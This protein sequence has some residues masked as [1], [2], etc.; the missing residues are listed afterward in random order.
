MKSVYKKNSLKKAALLVIVLFLFLFTG[1]A[2]AV[3]NEEVDSLIT[4]TDNLVDQIYLRITRLELEYV[5]ELIPLIND[6]LAYNMEAK[7]EASYLNYYRIAI[8][9]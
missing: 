2:G 8:P 6:V 4:D 7:N 9:G 1:S 3:T 5:D